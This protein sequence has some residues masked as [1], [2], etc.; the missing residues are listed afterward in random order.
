MFYVFI[1]IELLVFCQ[2]LIVCKTIETKVN[3]SLDSSLDYHLKE[4]IS[5]LRPTF[6]SRTQKFD[7]FLLFINY[8]VLFLFVF[9]LGKKVFFNQ[10]FKNQK[11]CFRFKDKFH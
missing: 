11:I 1:I 6:N 5:Q 4:A 8:F 3:S 10:N 9:N 2:Q 7:G